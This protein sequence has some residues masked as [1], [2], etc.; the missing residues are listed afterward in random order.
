MLGAVE[1]KLSAILAGDLAA[2]VH[3]DV[4]EAPGPPA[5]AAG[6]GAVLISLSTLS[7]TTLFE[8]E[9]FAFSGAQSR[10]ILPIQFGASVDYAIRPASNAAAA[11]ASARNLL[12]VDVSLISHALARP[13]LMNGKAFVVAD[14]DPGF[15]VLSFALSTGA[16][17]RDIDAASGLLVARLS[18]VGGAEIWPPGVVQNEGEIRAIDTVSVPLPVALAPSQ[19][20]L[21]AGQSA[22]VTARSLP[23]S[24]LLN[25]PSTRTPLQLFVTVLSDVPPAQSGSIT[26]GSA[27]AETGARL[28]DVT[29]PET[30][31]TYQA[32]AAAV[33]R[34]RIEYVAVHLATPEGQRGVFIGSVAL[35]LEPG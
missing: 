26:G 6:R 24:R 35:R 30:R 11:L 20:V 12:L 2:R 9:Q 28:I 21:R 14:P 34:S 3:L 8:R 1:Q 19:G 5:P 17:T 22:I 29:P 25:P 32:P 13:E 10:R 16:L 15:R 23:T 33:A 7:P 27:A 31:L 4:L 18:Y